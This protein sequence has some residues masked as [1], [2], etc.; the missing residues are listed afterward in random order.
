[1]WPL[2][3]H[4]IKHNYKCELTPGEASGHYEIHK[5]T[6]SHSHVKE[7][8][9]NPCLGVTTNNKPLMMTDYDSDVRYQYSISY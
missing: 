5:N 6:P 8:L 4:V 9:S 1:M 2:S 7:Y 3:M